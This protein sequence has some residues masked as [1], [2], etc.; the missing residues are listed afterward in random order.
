MSAEFEN[1]IASMPQALP[2]FIETELP[3]SL[4]VDDG[5]QYE[6]IKDLSPQSLPYVEAFVL[7]RLSTPEQAVEVENQAFSEGIIRYLGETLLRSLG[8]RWDF[9]NSGEIA[10]HMP[11]IRPDNSTGNELGDPIDVLGAILSALEVRTGEVF[12]A[13]YVK[14]L[15]GF[16]DQPP[17]RSTTG[18]EGTPGTPWDPTGARSE[19]ERE[20]LMAFLPTLQPEVDE[21]VAQHEDEDWA[22]DRASLV[23][24][25]SEVRSLFDSVDVLVSEENQVYANGALRFVGEAL[26]L[27]AG[28]IWRYGDPESGVY[29]DDDPR[30]N[31]PYLEFPTQGVDVVPWMLLASAFDDEDVLPTAYQALD[32]GS[33]GDAIEDQDDEEFSDDDGGEGEPPRDFSAGGVPRV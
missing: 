5:E 2:A 29:E 6:F 12:V 27:A 17:R 13:T 8:G 1:F 11:F 26:R 15:E 32:D 21:W 14:A 33:V 4:T 24:L 25:V 16:D 28:G 18:M 23:R 9:D 31:Q 19:G 10:D 30:L 22:F 3:E 7:S 20:F